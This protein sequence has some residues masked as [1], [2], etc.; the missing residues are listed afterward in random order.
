MVCGSDGKPSIRTAREHVYHLGLELGES[1]GGLAQLGGVGDDG[2]RAGVV[3][4]DCIHHTPTGFEYTPAPGLV[5]FL[6]GLPP[7]V[8]GAGPN[9]K[10]QILTMVLDGEGG[11]GGESTMKMFAKSIAS[12]LPERDQDALRERTRKLAMTSMTVNW[13]MTIRP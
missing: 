12:D 8:L 4:R 1:F 7:V 3:I 9:D 2:E 13:S 11:P 6:R 10:P 5:L